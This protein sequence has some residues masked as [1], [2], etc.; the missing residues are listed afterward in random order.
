MVYF[1]DW[2]DGGE[3]AMLSDFAIEK[4]VID[5]ANILV[6]SYTYEDYDGSAYVLFE[7]GGDLFEVHGGHCS[8]YGLEDQWEPEAVDV[9]SILRRLHTRYWGTKDGVASAIRRAIAV[10]TGDAN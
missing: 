5:G 8:C 10:H 1:H 9:A 4:S 3:A 7:R 2:A 6:A